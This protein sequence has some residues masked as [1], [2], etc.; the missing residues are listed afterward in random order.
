M[1]QKKPLN[2]DTQTKRK[3]YNDKER[4][5]TCQ[6]NYNVT[7]VASNKSSLLLKT[8]IKLMNITTI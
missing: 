5:L 8:I 4:G 3:E 1:T 6:T 2:L 7:E